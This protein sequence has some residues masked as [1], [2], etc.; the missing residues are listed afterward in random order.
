MKEEKKMSLGIEGKSLQEK[1]KMR[2]KI[3]QKD[4]DEDDE[5]CE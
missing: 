2:R 1:T 3:I 5:G 4:L